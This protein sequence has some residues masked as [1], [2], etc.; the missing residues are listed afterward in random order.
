MYTGNSQDSEQ[1]WPGLSA[2]GIDHEDILI[3]MAPKPVLVLSAKYD[4]FPIEGTRESVNRA[5]RFWDLYGKGDNIRLVECK[6]VH[7]YAEELANAAAGFFSLHLLGKENYPDKRKIRTNP[8]ARLWC[9]GS[10]QVRAEFTDA[11]GV[12][13]ENR[14]RWNEILD[15]RKMLNEEEQKNKAYEWLKERIYS[16]RKPCDLNCRF[17]DEKDYFGLNIRKCL[18]WS[19][20]GIMNHALLF[21][22]CGHK[23]KPMPVTI[24]FWEGGTCRLREHI[25][26]IRKACSEGRA[27]IVPDV[28]GVGGAAPNPFNNMPAL[29]F[30]G[31][32][33][34]LAYD[35]IWL[36]DS[37]TALRTY[38]AIRSLDMIEA[39]DDLDAGDITV[40]SCDSYGIYGLLAAF[41][42]R[43]VRWVDMPEDIQSFSDVVCRRYYE[44]YD[45]MSVILPGALKY[46]DIPDIKRWIESNH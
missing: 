8:P 1:N 14:V 43:R 11:R 21:M 6:S 16:F 40:Y 34:K 23:S 15:K 19:Q 10:G 31:V 39:C 3:S 7:R 42:D 9:T 2:K 28:S 18:W 32:I 45:I 46:F 35:L 27:V 38:D 41:A 13:E 29:E 12:F 33:F 25:N 36:D 5:K 30:S 24:P 37:I 17:Y 22:E 4:F 20:E 44:P 26:W